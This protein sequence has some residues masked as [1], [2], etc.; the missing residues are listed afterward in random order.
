MRVSAAKGD[1][2][3]RPPKDRNFDV[4]LNGAPLPRGTV[5][6]ADEEKGEALVV[7]LGADG[8]PIPDHL[9]QSCRTSTLRG[10]V[11]IVP[12]VREDGE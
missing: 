8:R 3:F 12:V 4:F 9:N 7:L 1:P 11:R 2:G 6:T 5:I 10:S